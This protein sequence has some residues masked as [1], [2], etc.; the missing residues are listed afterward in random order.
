LPVKGAA[1]DCRY[2]G[3]QATQGSGAVARG[4]GA[5]YAQWA[6]CNVANEDCCRAERLKVMVRERHPEAL[7][8]LA[9]C[10]GE[11]LLRAGRR[12]CRSGEEAEDAV[13]DTFVAAAS[14][15]EDFRGDGS[16]E[17]WLVRIVAS[18]CRRLSRGQKNDPTRHGVE[19]TVVDARE[20]PEGETARRELGTLLHRSLLDLS[21]E[22]RQVLLLAEVDGLG[23]PEIAEQLG[24]SPGAVRARLTRAR[25]RLR[26]ALLPFLL[27]PPA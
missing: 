25:A 14:H 12:H 19:F 27:D 3:V 5:R 22:D 15:L 13:Q 6:V 10:Y 7:D 8:R 20:S 9:R 24:V 17:G 1:L 23:G 11:R 21:A 18:A 4:L 26:T 2:R 16:L